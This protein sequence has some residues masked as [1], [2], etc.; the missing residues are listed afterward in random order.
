[1]TNN[2]GYG[3]NVSHNQ[4]AAGQ[5]LVVQASGGNSWGFGYLPVGNNVNGGYTM[6]NNDHNA[7][8]VYNEANNQWSSVSNNSNNFSYSNG[9]VVTV[10]GGALQQHMTYFSTNGSWS[11]GCRGSGLKTAI[12]K[13]Q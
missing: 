10:S 5:Y 13:V 2:T 7:P 12:F 9:Y 6:V 1:V 11:I 4:N 8:Y 3:V